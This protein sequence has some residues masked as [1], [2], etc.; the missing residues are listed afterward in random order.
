MEAPKN[1]YSVS[2]KRPIHLNDPEHQTDSSTTELPEAE[3]REQ[4]M[5]IM[6]KWKPW[7]RANKCFDIRLVET[8]I[9][10]I[11]VNLDG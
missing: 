9:N 5:E 8:V 6:E 11:P 3:N 1:K 7:L 2:W 10:I 4:A